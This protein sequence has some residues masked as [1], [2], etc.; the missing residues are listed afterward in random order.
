MRRVFI[1]GAGGFIGRH[2]LAAMALGDDHIIALSRS[3]V[4]KNDRCNWIEGTIFDESLVE[5]IFQ[6]LKPTHLIHLAWTAAPVH[7][8]E[9]PANNAWLKASE[10]LME[11]AT[12]TSVSHIISMGTSAEYIWDGG[13]CDEESTALEPWSTYGRSK[14]ALHATAR[15]LS[16]ERGVSLSW[17]RLFFP[18]GPGEPP[19]KFLSAMITHGLRDAKIILRDPERKLDVIHIDDVIAAIGVVLAACPDQAVNVACGRGVMLRELAQIIASEL[20]RGRV[21]IIE[22]AAE[23]PAPD[24]IASV[25]RLRSLGWTPQRELIGSVTKMVRDVTLVNKDVP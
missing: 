7:F 10:A 1:T 17:L 14:A 16:V 21:K 4:P 3:P 8:W 11:L 25:A 19:E 20:G 24:V 2:L 5:A 6:E 15:F 22:E 13:L 12:S 18:Y 23:H 9:D